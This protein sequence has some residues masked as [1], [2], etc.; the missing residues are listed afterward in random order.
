MPIHS[1]DQLCQWLQGCRYIADIDHFGERDVWTHPLDF[2]RGKAGD[3]EDHALWA[4]RKLLEMDIPAYFVVGLHRNERDET[5]AHAW[6]YLTRDER[7]LVLETT[8][9]RQLLLPLD[10]VVKRYFP[11]Y[12]VT[13][14]LETVRFT[15]EM[16][17]FREAGR[18]EGRTT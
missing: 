17:R 4:W 10:Q 12:G 7:P 6:V 3:C 11:K 16:H 18:A 9:K 14:D 15:I 13:A 8:A 1:L 2:E 5:V